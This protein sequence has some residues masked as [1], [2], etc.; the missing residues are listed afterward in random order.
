[1]LYGK[2]CRRGYFRIIVPLDDE[3]SFDYDISNEKNK[4]ADKVPIN[5]LT[6]QQKVIFQF[7]NENGQITSHDAEI[8]LGVKQRRARGIL[9]EMVDKHIL[10]RQGA[11][12]STVY[13]LNTEVNGDKNVRE[14]NR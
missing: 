3:Y 13:V 14:T 10:K 7:I 5:N 1:M 4:S 2:V 11:Y 12:K 6:A 9:A 8:L